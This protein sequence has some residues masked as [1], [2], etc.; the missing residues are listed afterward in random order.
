VVTAAAVAL[1]GLVVGGMS[2][3]EP[4]REVKQLSGAAWLASSRAGQVTLLD[5]SSA[6]VSAQVSVAPPGNVLSVVQQGATAYAVDQTAGT[7]RR[8][9]GATFGLTAPEVPIADAHAGLVALPGPGVVYAVDTRRGILANTDPLTLSR[10]GEMVSLASELAAGTVAV[11]DAGTLW[12][13]DNATG[14]LT[15]VEGGKRSVRRQL[16]RPGKNVLTVV[17]GHPVVVDLTE[18]RAIGVDRDSGGATGSIELDLRASDTVEVSGSARADRL[19]LVVSRGLLTVCELADGRCDTAIPLNEGSTFGAAVEAG[20]RVFVPDFTTGQVW[21]ID[22]ARSRVVGTPKVLTPPGKFT[23]LAR[24]GVVFYNDPDSER[25]GVIRLDGSVAAV[26][27]YGAKNPGGGI[28][29]PD[30]ANP[31]PSDPQRPNNPDQPSN[32]RRPDS[33][34]QPNDPRQPDDPRQAN[35]PRQ[36]ENPPQPNNPNPD[37]P[38][39]QNPDPGNPD[40]NNPDPNN[41]DPGDPDPGNPNPDPPPDLDIVVNKANPVEN[42]VITL[43]VDNRTGAE[44]VDAAWNFG[45]GEQGNGVTTTH[46]WAQARQTPY[47]ISV[48]ATMPD[49]RP[50]TTSTNI[51]VTPTPTFRLSVT[52]PGGGGRITGGGIDCP[53]ACTAN[54]TPDTRIT[55]SAVP[56]ASHQLGSW[57]GAC[58]GG[59]STCEVTMDSAKDVSYTFTTP[60]PQ[61]TLAVITPDG[62][63][64]SGGGLNCPGTCSIR[65]NQG[66]TVTLTATPDADHVFDSWAGCSSAGPTCTVALISNSGE[67]NCQAVGAVFRLRPPPEITFL[68]CEFTGNGSFSCDFGAIDFTSAVWKVGSS[69]FPD[70][71]SN[72][73]RGGCIADTFG[74]RMT[75]SNAAGSDTQS[76]TVQCIGEPK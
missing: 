52:I 15:R 3:G 44:P 24:D 46:K 45:D 37:N 32:P 68:Q 66:S 5:G 27:K 18:R 34:R 48:T 29:L 40:P 28:P 69:E 21:I 56:D 50:F 4:P 72:S 73:L 75:V 31:Q 26:V 76:R 65:G 62:G 39:Q 61:V 71:G 9:D 16:A 74:V 41:P 43:R 8:V 58:A 14:D 17:D 12:G 7:V 6:E 54:L 51:T 20:N 47:L 70:D 10:R 49:G 59:A 11:D 25:A 64:V 30:D 35:D 13:I 63:R 1:G 55:L 67:C 23:L 53:A 2:S 22:L 19:Y 36:P 33:P 42:E 60:V 57:G 38:N